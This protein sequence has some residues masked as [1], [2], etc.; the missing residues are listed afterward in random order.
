MLSNDSDEALSQ[1][2]GPFQEPPLDYPRD[3]IVLASAF[4]RWLSRVYVPR[5]LLRPIQKLSRRKYRFRDDLLRAMVENRFGIKV[6]KY[7]YGYKQFCF[8]G[9]PVAEIGAFCS[10]APGINLS[11]GNHP[12]HLVSTSPVFYLA[13]IATRPRPEVVQKN[14]P[15][16]I[17]HDVWIGLNAT[18]LT[19]IR[20]GHGA[21][22]AAGAVVTKDVP[23]Y[24]IVGGVPARL[25]RYRCDGLTRERL[26]RTRW[27]LWPDDRLRAEA[28]SFLDIA[29]FNP[30]D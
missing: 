24:A 15:I 5:Y 18:L 17:G 19:G 22:I 20:I 27:W 1:V 21:V 2:L 26:L 28:E 3:N 29:R 14:G 12:T 7:S 13:G 16:Y 25:I 23:P 6:G 30:V 11:L 4:D 8:K 9:S 10:F